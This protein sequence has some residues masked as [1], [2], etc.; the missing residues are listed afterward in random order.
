M[1]VDGARAAAAAKRDAEKAASDETKRKRLRAAKLYVAAEEAGEK[2][3]KGGWTIDRCCRAAGI[4]EPTPADNENVRD[5]R[6]PHVRSARLDLTLDPWIESQL[7]ADAGP[8]TSKPNTCEDDLV[9]RAAE[10]YLEA[11]NNGNVR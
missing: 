5:Q 10:I 4:A 2:M 11:F 6:I 3:G 8:S 1:I 9:Q 7:N